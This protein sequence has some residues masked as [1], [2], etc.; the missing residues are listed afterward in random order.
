M[1]RKKDFLFIDLFDLI[2]NSDSVSCNTVSSGKLLV[3]NGLANIWKAGV[4]FVMQFRYS[5]L[6][7]SSRK[8]HYTWSRFESKTFDIDTRKRLIENC[9]DIY[10]TEN[11]MWKCRVN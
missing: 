11:W 3:Y 5:Q 8:K 4:H 9:V 2:N 6:S 7:P 10:I 1:N